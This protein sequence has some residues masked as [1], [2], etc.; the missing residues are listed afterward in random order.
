[1]LSGFLITRILLA[2]K[3]AGAPLRH[4]LARRAL[5]IFPIYYLTLLVVYLVSRRPDVIWSA[6]YLSNFYQSFNFDPGPLRTTWSLA[7]EEHFYLFWPLV[8]YRLSVRTSRRV[9][10]GV[11]IPGALLCSAAAIQFLEPLNAGALIY[12][13]TMFRMASLALGALLAYDE[14]RV[15]RSSIRT[16]LAGGAAL[17]TGVTV[18]ALGRTTA[19]EHWSPLIRLVGYSSVSVGTVMIVIALNGC[20]RLFSWLLSNPPLRYVGRI[21]YGLY[22]FHYPIYFVLGL[23]LPRDA[24]THTLIV[25][26]WAVTLTFMVASA[27][28]FLIESPILRFKTLFTVAPTRDLPTAVST[29]TPIAVVDAKPRQA[30]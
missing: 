23:N 24:Y 14:A 7:V 11:L 13:G 27:S 26:V 21:S 17:L 30:A 3:Q 2:D 1:M 12:R 22:L 19:M 8:V 15:R 5:R 10:M 16:I 20:S 29:D 25:S 28:W 6:T 9:A 18:I 4:F